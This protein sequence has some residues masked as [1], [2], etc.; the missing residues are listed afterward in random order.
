MCVRYKVNMMCVFRLK[1]PSTAFLSQQNIGSC[2][3]HVTTFTVGIC[4]HR[5]ICFDMYILLPWL[6]YDVK[7]HA[8]PMN[9]ENKN[10]FHFTSSRKC[11]AKT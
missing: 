8:P 7:T 2:V 11:V 10:D 1:Q 4:G 6:E 5:C 3:F 9:G